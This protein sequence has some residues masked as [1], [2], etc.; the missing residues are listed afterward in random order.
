[1]CNKIEKSPFNTKIYIFNETNSTQIKMKRMVESNEINEF[2]IV[3][4]INQ[5]SGIGRSN[6]R[7]FSSSGSLTFSICISES[8]VNK[9]IKASTEINLNNISKIHELALNTICD[10]LNR[11]YS[12]KSFVKWPNDI[13]LKTSKICGILIDKYSD[14]LIIGVGINLN[15]DKIMNYDTIFGISGV[16]IDPKE[17]LKHFLSCFVNSNFPKKSYYEMSSYLYWQNE[18]LKVVD[19]NPLEIHCENSSGKRFCFGMDNFSYSY[20]S[21]SIHKKL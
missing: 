17:F 8:Y 9:I 12:V 1:M 13:Y 14:L 20:L 21:K 10:I 16:Q 2:D 18:M 19:F 3:W 15:E 11:K 7:W 5:K 6:N 4:A